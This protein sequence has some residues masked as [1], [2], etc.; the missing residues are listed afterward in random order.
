MATCKPEFYQ[1]KLETNFRSDEFSCKLVQFID[2][3]CL[4]NTGDASLS[5]L[6]GVSLG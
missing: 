1:Y 2:A 3:H 5:S 4:G 6:N